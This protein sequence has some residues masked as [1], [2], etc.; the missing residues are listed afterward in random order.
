M[1]KGLALFGG[2]FN[3]VHNGHIALARA[4][5]EHYLLE[6]VALLPCYQPVHRDLPQTSPEYR[7]QMIELAIQ[8]YNELTLDSCELDRSGPSYAVDT[9]QEKKQKHSQQTLYWIMGVDSFNSLLSWKN[10]NKILQLAHLIVCTRPEVK[11]DEHVFPDHITTNAEDLQKTSAG[12][13]SLFDGL[14]NACSSS[15]IREQLNQTTF[16]ETSILQQCLAEPVLNFI[17]QHKLYE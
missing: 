9:L 13:I 6:Q 1:S 2:T 16:N 3:P 10:P 11:F 5:A 7:R 12:K 8:P 4:V 14:N 15:K 17:K